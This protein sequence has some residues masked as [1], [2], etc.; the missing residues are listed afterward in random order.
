[1]NM[2]DPLVIRTVRPEEVETITQ[3]AVAAWEPIYAHAREVL[4]ERI[5]SLRSPNWQAEKAR[6][7]RNACHDDRMRVLVAEWDGEI[8][9]FVTYCPR[10]TEQMAVI[11]N[12][13]VHPD[14]QGRGI[15]TRMYERVLE[16]LRAEGVAFVMVTTGGDPAH[17]PARRAYE[18][19]G[20]DRALPSIDYY[21]EL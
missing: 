12:N 6:Q 19:V 1:M 3:I 2:S 11:G 5:F 10:R 16:D 7:V 21:M 17:A 9:G 20:F 14:Y 15:A 18:K 13:A 4:G 8:A